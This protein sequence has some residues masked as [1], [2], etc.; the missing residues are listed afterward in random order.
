MFNTS[1]R[2]V[3]TSIYATY[4]RFKIHAIPQSSHMSFPLCLYSP[5]GA[6]G[7]RD[8]AEFG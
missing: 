8:L 4:L 7:T 2:D 5:H 6:L 3:D 1:S